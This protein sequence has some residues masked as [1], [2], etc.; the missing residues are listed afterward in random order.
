MFMASTPEHIPNAAPLEPAFE[1][2]LRSVDYCDDL[3]TALQVS[4]HPR[5]RFC[6]VALRAPEGL[7][8]TCEG[9]FRR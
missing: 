2:I 4:G 3:I 9:G 5:S 6:F 1:Y 8:E 7:R